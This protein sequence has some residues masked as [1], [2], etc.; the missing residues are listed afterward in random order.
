MYYYVIFDS[1]FVSKI[2]ALDFSEAS[3]LA[4]EAATFEDGQSV[5]LDAK[6]AKAVA[7]NIL[8]KK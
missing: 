4:D 2:T 3:F 1:G 7:K 5:L 6:T 8:G